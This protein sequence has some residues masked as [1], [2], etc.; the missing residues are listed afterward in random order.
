MYMCTAMSRVIV[1]A[2]L[3]PQETGG[4]V[5]RWISLQ[6]RSKANSEWILAFI[7][8]WKQSDNRGREVSFVF[9]TLGS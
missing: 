9:E 2:I 4:F 6:P 8:R 3:C 1:L 7:D 5:I